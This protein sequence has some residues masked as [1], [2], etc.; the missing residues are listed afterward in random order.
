MVYLYNL[1]EWQ[2]SNN[3]HYSQSWLGE[4]NLVHAGYSIF[5]TI[6]VVE[7]STC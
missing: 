3:S 4:K 6:K 7:C 1:I 5:E 2:I